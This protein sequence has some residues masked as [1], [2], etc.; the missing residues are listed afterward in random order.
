M[1]LH[2]TRSAE[3]SLPTDSTYLARDSSNKPGTEWIEKRVPRCYGI[4][5]STTKLSPEGPNGSGRCL[6]SQP[7]NASR[8]GSPSITP[9][10]PAPTRATLFTLLVA[11]HVPIDTPGINPGFTT[12]LAAVHLAV[13]AP[14]INTRFTAR[15]AALPATIGVMITALIPVTRFVAILTLVTILVT[16]RTA[17]AVT[18]EIMRT[19]LIAVLFPETS[20]V[21]IMVTP[22]AT[23]PA[24]TVISPNIGAAIRVVVPAVV[25]PTVLPRVAA[26]IARSNTTAEEYAHGSEHCN[27]FHGGLLRC[28]PDAFSIAR[29]VSDSCYQW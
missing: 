7:A 3:V 10:L 13:N 19:A 17:I 12:L 11:I 21:M 15:L 26:L 4:E 27:P 14:V 8:S 2:V 20:P 25:I 28:L 5:S 22:A 1:G 23:V 16:T 29:R 18:I 24:P 9:P 6:T